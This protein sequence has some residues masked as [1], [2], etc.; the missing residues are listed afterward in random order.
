MGST[1]EDRHWNS[2]AA[3]VASDGDRMQD[4][5]FESDQD[6]SLAASE[7]ES[8][9]TWDV[10]AGC[11]GMAMDKILAVDQ[12]SLQVAAKIQNQTLFLLALIIKPLILQKRME[13]M[14]YPK[15]DI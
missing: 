3:G 5:Q 7:N 1:A 6:M 12:Y 9:D 2:Y 15:T 10:L 14:I 4:V 8:I 13:C 11:A